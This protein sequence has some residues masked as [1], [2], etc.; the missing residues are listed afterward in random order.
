[1]KGA[2]DLIPPL[3]ADA[4]DAYAGMPR[5]LDSESETEG[6]PLPPKLEE[7]PKRPRQQRSR[8]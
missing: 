1:M 8:P 2:E 3:A 7:T 4:E 5:M 6:A